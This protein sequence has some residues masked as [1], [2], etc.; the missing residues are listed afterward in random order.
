MK[1]WL[2]VV[3]MLAIP[4]VVFGAPAM[5]Q[6]AQDDD[7][8]AAVSDEA[9][10]WDSRLNPKFAL[11]LGFGLVNLDEEAFEDDV[12]PYYMASFRIRVGNRPT[13]SR[14]PGIDTATLPA[15]RDASSRG[16]AV[17]R[18]PGASRRCGGFTGSVPPGR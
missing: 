14:A 15:G 2:T 18:S 5:A 16:S 13:R 3:A 10:D 8:Q 9:E 7:E 17:W 11:G 6:D 12:E 4:L 1:R